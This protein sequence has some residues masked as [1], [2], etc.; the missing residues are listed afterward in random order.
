MNRRRFIKD[1][2]LLAAL[3]KPVHGWMNSN[4]ENDSLTAPESKRSGEPVLIDTNIHLFPYP[5]RELKYGNTDDLLAKLKQHSVTEAWAG[6]FYALFHKNIDHINASL[7]K[8]CRIKGEGILLPF[9]TV[10]PVFPD[11]EEDLR[12]CHEQYKMPGIRLYPGYHGYPLD[13]EN[14]A[15]LLQKASARDLLIQI[16][17]DIQDERMQHPRVDAEAV[18]VAPLAD[19]LKELAGARVQLINSFRHVRGERLQVMI[20]ETGVLF[21]ISNLDHTAAIELMLRG[22]HPYVHGVSI[23]ADRLLFGSHM[24]YF[25]L[26]NALFKFME[27]AL[28]ADEA[29]SIMYGNAAAFRGNV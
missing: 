27:S 10:N 19:L 13:D 23:P 9:G 4:P 20:E 24:P 25:P 28:S 14:F 2:M 21:E 17:I 8:E 15:R 12:R 1:T 29:K 22:E 26:E 11:W 18:D 3:A 16:A 5:F 6:S 7:A